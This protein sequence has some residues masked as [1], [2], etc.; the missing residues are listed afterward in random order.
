M[1]K[2]IIAERQNR[3]TESQTYDKQ[4]KKFL[5]E[6]AIK[7][8]FL[9]SQERHE[10][11]MLNHF[12]W[13]DKETNQGYHIPDDIEYNRRDL[14]KSEADIYKHMYYDAVAY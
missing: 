11:L 9:I 6:F 4:V 5:G 7:D 13:V 12:Y 14:G 10:D 3:E 8:S 2:S 1:T